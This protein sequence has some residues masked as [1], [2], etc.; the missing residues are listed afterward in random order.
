MTELQIDTIRTNYHIMSEFLR[1]NYPKTNLQL[2]TSF[3]MNYS[4]FIRNTGN[5]DLY[6]IPEMFSYFVS[7]T[8]LKQCDL[9]EGR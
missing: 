1:R 6:T 2:Y 7:K 8:L 4:R 5:I 9:K 3:K